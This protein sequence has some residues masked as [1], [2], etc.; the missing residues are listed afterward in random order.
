MEEV[1]LLISKKG[2]L[3]HAPDPNLPLNGVYLFF[4]KGQKLSITNQQYDRVVRIGINE[5]PNRFRDRVRGHYRGNI[6]GSVFRENVG[7]ALLET[8]GKKPKETYGTKKQ[9]R[10]RNS[11]G[12][13]EEDISK[14][15]STEFTFKAFDIDFEKLYSYESTLLAAFSIY[16]QWRRLGKQLDLRNWLG[17]HSYSRRHKI[18]RS[19]LWNCE[20]VIL[21]GS[22][23][24]LTLERPPVDFNFQMLSKSNLNTVF[25]DLSQKLVGS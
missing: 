13:L 7:W 18:K 15:F 14:L 8:S 10:L 11:G 9:Y 4:E 20:G 6:E 17:L 3:F 21:I 25:A 23:E 16:Y 5:K 1:H 22:I 2:R 19:G 12:P 24:P